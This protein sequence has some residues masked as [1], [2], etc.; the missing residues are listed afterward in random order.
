MYTVAIIGCGSTG[1]GL[2]AQLVEVL[3]E[4]PNAL[5]V[6]VFEKSGKLGPGLAYSCH[7]DL[8][9]NSPAGKVTVFDKDNHHFLR[10]LASSRE[11]WEPHY[12][13]LALMREF[14]P[15]WFSPRAL[16]GIYMNDMFEQSCQQAKEKGILVEVLVEEV[17]NM[18]E[19]EKN[20]M[21]IDIVKF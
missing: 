2:L 9:M 13:S 18:E 3:N 8:M 16:I 17:V 11:K 5:R 12:P 7:P 15:E 21:L 10:W 20:G 4:A 19:D 6:L 14:D 1:V